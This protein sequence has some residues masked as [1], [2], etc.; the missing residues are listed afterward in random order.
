MTEEQRQQ[1][2]KQR[3]ERLAA[4]EQ[5]AAELQTIMTPDQ[6]KAYQA[7]MEKNMRQGGARRGGPRG[8]QQEQPKQE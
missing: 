3:A 2:E 8:E 1:M 4:M 6:F 5:Y 7:D